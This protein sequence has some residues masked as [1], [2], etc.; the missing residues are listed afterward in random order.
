VIRLEFNGKKTW[1]LT[2]YEKDESLLLRTSDRAKAPQKE[3]DGS[4]PPSKAFAETIADH[5]L[6][7]QET[8]IH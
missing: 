3:G 5:P 2:E 7:S 1:L 8:S 4:T 6:E